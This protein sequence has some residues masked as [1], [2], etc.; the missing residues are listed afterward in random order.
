MHRSSRFAVRRSA[1]PGSAIPSR[2]LRPIAGRP[3]ARS[4]F[5]AGIRPFVAAELEA[6]G[7]AEVLGDAAEAFARLERAHVLGQRST[8]EHVRVHWR[9]LRWGLRYRRPM[10]VVGQVLRIAG[11]A[12]KTAVGW[13]LTGNTGGADVSAFRTQPVPPDLQALIDRAAGRPS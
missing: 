4:R 10:E 3:L 2:A 5:A 7:K 8:V 13:V 11:A 6:A 1:T 9:M 12:T